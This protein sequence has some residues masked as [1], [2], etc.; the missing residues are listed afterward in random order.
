MKHIIGRLLS[1]M[2]GISSDELP[3][4]K[5]VPLN[6]EYGKNRIT[7][8]FDYDNVDTTLSYHD[9]FGKTSD[10]TSRNNLLYV[11]KGTTVIRRRYPYLW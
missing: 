5:I 6:V 7:I 10:I 8:T 9:I 1:N 4:R 2:T 3:E 11:N